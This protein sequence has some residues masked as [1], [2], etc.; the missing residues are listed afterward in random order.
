M[1]KDQVTQADAHALPEVYTREEAARLLGVSAATVGK[2]V[3]SGR[4]RAVQAG[5][6]KLR[7]HIRIPASAIHEFLANT[8]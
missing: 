4:L 1:T 7:S 2:L 6:G 5:F 3:R 8:M